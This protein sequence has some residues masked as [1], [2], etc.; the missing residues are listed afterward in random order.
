MES[1]M[2]GA[3]E[4]KDTKVIVVLTN[5]RKRKINSGFRVAA[6]DFAADL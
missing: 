5:L 1:R 3:L 2:N 4:E 6:S